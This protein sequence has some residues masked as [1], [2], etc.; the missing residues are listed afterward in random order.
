MKKLLFL[1]M[2]IVLFAGCAS[3]QK[4]EDKIAKFE[5]KLTANVGKMTQDVK[6]EYGK[7]TRYSNQSPL[8]ANETGGF[9]IYDERQ[10]ESDNSSCVL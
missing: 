8:D 6:K 9:M 3:F 1:S 5:Q 2:F 4:P 7:P 10:A